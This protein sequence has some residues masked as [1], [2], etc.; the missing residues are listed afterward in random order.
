MYGYIMV[1]Q[2]ES[3]QKE[4]K[5]TNSHNNNNKKKQNGDKDNNNIHIG[6]NGNETQSI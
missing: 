2:F 3:I 6:F 1:N 4:K 5:I